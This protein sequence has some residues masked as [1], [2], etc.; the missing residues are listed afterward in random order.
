VRQEE[1]EEVD[2]GATLSCNRCNAAINWATCCVN[3]AGVGMI[4]A[5]N[6]AGA[7]A[8]PT[9]G[10]AAVAVVVAA[11]SEDEIV[12]SLDNGNDDDDDADVDH[13]W[14]RSV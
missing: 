13:G 9:T 6:G 5:T 7:G 4:G 8:E 14:I 1:N 12:E 2:V 3:S 11:T 10:V